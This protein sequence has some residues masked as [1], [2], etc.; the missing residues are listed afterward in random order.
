MVD[1][2]EL[3]DEI[4]QNLLHKMLK[5]Y[6]RVRSSSLA[7]DITGRKTGVLSKKSL[8]KNLKKSTEEAL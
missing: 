3:I 4:K 1:N 2:T 5:L 6:L 8:R 7:K